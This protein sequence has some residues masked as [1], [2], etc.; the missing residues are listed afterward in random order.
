MKN[1]K[2]LIEVY[3]ARLV[4]VNRH[5]EHVDLLARQVHLAAF[6]KRPVIYMMYDDCHI[7]QLLINDL[8]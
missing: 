2:E 4:D 3:A 1:R 7:L 5:E 6:D 8:L